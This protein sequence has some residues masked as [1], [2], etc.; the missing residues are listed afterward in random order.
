[1]CTACAAICSMT[2]GLCQAEEAA[3]VAD[4]QRHHDAVHLS[5]GSRTLQVLGRCA[6]LVVCLNGAITTCTQPP[7]SLLLN[8]R[9]VSTPTPAGQGQYACTA[10]LNLSIRESPLPAT[11]CYYVDIDWLLCGSIQLKAIDSSAVERQLLQTPG[12]HKRMMM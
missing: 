9:R 3:Y 10:I 1:V 8:L 2:P 7:R 12:G 6:F 5:R 4:H 11:P